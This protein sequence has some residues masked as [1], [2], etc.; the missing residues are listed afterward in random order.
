VVKKLI[1]ACL[2]R[3]GVN[4]VS[5]SMDEHGKKKSVSACLE[6]VGRSSGWLSV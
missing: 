6:K 2:E 3:G 1:S 4:K 5:F